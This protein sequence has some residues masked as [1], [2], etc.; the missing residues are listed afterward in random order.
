M[1]VE[2]VLAA[3]ELVEEVEVWLER[4]LMLMLSWRLGR[5]CLAWPGRTIPFWLRCN[6]LNDK[7]KSKCD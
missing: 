6:A 7:L 2:V 3:V 4:G 1:A 5:L